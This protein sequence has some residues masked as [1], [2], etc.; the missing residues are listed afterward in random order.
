MIPRTIDLSADDRAGPA[1]DPLGT[2]PVTGLRSGRALERTTSFNAAGHGLSG[3]L[4]WFAAWTALVLLQATA[5]SAQK[6]VPFRSALM[7]SAVNYYTLALFSAA[8][9]RVSAWIPARTRSSA[10][11]VAAHFAMAVMVIG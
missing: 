2:Q 7:S 4:V 3:A 10:A 5:V 6:Q 1:V 8:V 11:A 9:W